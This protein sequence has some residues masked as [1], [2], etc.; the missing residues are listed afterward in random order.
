MSQAEL[1]HLPT[2]APAPAGPV[3]AS[4]G[5]PDQA[6][7]P[8]VV[9]AAEIH[10]LTDATL[11]LH[12]GQLSV[13]TYDR[14][15]LTP[16]VVHFS[17]G[18][19]HRAHQLLYFDEL[20]ER[21]VSDGWGVVG[22]GLHSRTMK[23][24]LAPQD[25]LYTVV[26]RSPDGERA[27][28][29]GVMVD[30]HFAPDD[31][32]AV[33]D[34]LADERTRMVSLTITDS[35]Y[36]LDARTGLFDADDTDIRWDVAH[37]SRPRTVFGFLVE[38]LD[39]RRRAGLPPFSVVSCDNM[40][41]NG[42]AARAAVV[43]FARLRDEVLARWIADRVAFPSS[44]VDR[45]TPH[46]TPEEREAVAQ[47]YGVDDRWPVITEPFSQWVIEDTFSAGRP[48]LDSVGVRFVADVGRYELMKTRLLNASHCALGYLGSL[49]GHPSLDH[50]MADPVF[51]RYV[52]RLMDAE[53]TP[54]LPP[55][56]GIDLADYKRSLLRRFANPAIAD[57]LPRLCRRGSTK[58]PHHLLPSLRQ[59]IEENRPHGLLTLAVAGW[60]RYLRG[61]D[62][63][64]RP[65]P[66]EDVLAERLQ[67]LARAGGTDPR[68]L[69]GET[70]LF[71]D[72]GRHEAF[73]A[74]LQEALIALD[75]DGVRATT[76]A[77]TLA[78]AAQPR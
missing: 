61:T 10:P 52:T 75:R 22:V 78:P 28:V 62:E 4:A 19:F 12:E 26:E 53:V 55:P 3:P 58:M 43:G 46:T 44:M 36:R 47:R 45:I 51:A 72:L 18:G 23:D 77:R 38:A 29:V 63:A 73:V 48:P 14:S 9:A 40:H 66:V 32:A 70:S 15:A 35:G 64:G 24:A 16:A 59:A 8:N 30:Y 54:L 13:P 7:G 17:V 2:T 25:H 67:R 49:A 76:T 57:G 20:A 60:F 34:L 71:G 41:R 42:D 1:L 31:P 5:F 27:R 37:P 69:L 11:A 50:V 74:Q 56:D 39:R 33:V 68:P 6:E 21:R 65:V